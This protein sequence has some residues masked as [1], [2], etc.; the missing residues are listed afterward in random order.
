MKFSV[1]KNINKRRA[2]MVLLTKPLRESDDPRLAKLAFEQ[3]EKLKGE[4]E[5]L[6]TK[7]VSW[8][9][10]ALVKFHKT[11][12][13]KYLEIN[14]ESLPKSAYREAKAK[15]ETGRKRIIGK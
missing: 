9:L 5:I 1:D 11:E 3:V 10:R 6:I 12:V 14:K 13:A 7:A 15:V 8:L 2:S 4:N